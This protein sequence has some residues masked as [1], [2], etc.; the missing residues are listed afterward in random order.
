MSKV[1]VWLYDNL[2][3]PDPNDFYGKVKPQGTL[4]NNDIADAMI[5]EGTEYQKET[6]LNILD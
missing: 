6:I 3:T 4:R 2:L 5:K 1:N